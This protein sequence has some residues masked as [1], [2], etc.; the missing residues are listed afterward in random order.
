[1]IEENQ[2]VSLM[3][4][5]VAHPGQSLSTLHD[6]I[7]SLSIQAAVMDASI[8]HVQAQVKN[9]ADQVQS[10][11]VH[12]DSTFDSLTESNA[13]LVQRVTTIE[14]Q[15]STIQDTQFA[16]LE[17][18]SQMMAM[19][20]QLTSP[21]GEQVAD[22]KKGEKLAKRKRVVD[23]S[24][25]RSNKDGNDENDG[26]D[27]D[28]QPLAKR[29]PSGSRTGISRSIPK[30]STG[31][32][33]SSPSTQQ[34]SKSTRDGKEKRQQ[35]ESL[36]AQSLRLRHEVVKELD[37]GVDLNLKNSGMFEEVIKSQKV[38]STT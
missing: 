35:P 23:D 1:M 3:E 29:R 37:S 25:C 11:R 8:L 14:D 19:L 15:L 31:V 24:S 17:N 20:L 34:T 38:I 6:A 27:D 7:N 22:V 13:N 21:M 12:T 4:N 32:S 30:P 28:D 18:Q 10:S 36:L 9:V 5:D 26:D 2:S 16:M 33:E